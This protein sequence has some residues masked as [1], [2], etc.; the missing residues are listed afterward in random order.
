M[1]A[2]SAP[3]ASALGIDDSEVF[4]IQAPQNT[5]YF[6]YSDTSQ[7]SKPIGVCSANPIDWTATGYIKGMTLHTQMEGIDTDSDLVN[8]VTGAPLFTDM[9]VVL[10][11]GPC[12]QVLV[13][14]YETNKM[15]PVYFGAQDEK[16]YWFRR[17][18]SRIDE[19]GLL[20]SSHEDMFVLEHFLDSNGNTALILYGYTGQGTFAGARFFK[21]VIDSNIRNY[22][23]SY[24]IFHWIDSDN[25]SFPDMNEINATPVAYG[26]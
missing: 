9:S 21:T 14:Y 22:I 26:D 7:H 17:D 18:G 1:V 10:S 8:Q 25:D 13:K 15:A 12:V 2:T 11:G 24:Y 16:C 6:I 19:T 4:V 23:H 5:V 20:P 3:K